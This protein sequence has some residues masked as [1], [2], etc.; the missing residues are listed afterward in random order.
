MG[1]IIFITGGARS[2]KSNFALTI[3]KKKKGK[4]AFIATAQAKDAEMKE[5]IALHKARRPKNWATFEEP[6]NL[7]G[8]IRDIGHSF[9][10]V[11]IDC[12]TLWVTNLIMKKADDACIEK[13]ALKMLDAINKS[14][15]NCIFITNE[16]GSGIV[17][18]NKLARR[19]RDIAGRIDQLVAQHANEMYLMVS[20]IPLKI[21]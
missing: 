21:K 20:G 10:T 19:F 14:R 8:C 9:K 13:E 7:E 16:I 6:Y 12:L 1:N 3:A 5:R 11:I 2:G 4:V 15:I 18:D 17:P